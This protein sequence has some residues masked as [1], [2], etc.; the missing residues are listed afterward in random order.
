MGLFANETCWELRKTVVVVVVV[1][2]RVRAWRLR[3]LEKLASSGLRGGVGVVGARLKAWARNSTR[4]S[5]GHP[6]A[7]AVHAQQGRRCH[8]RGSLR[9]DLGITRGKNGGVEQGLGMRRRA[10]GAARP[11]WS[12]PATGWTTGDKVIEGQISEEERER[13]GLR[14]DRNRGGE[15]GGGGGMKKKIKVRG[16]LVDCSYII[17]SVAWEE[18]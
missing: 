16:F 2:V 14:G 15:R 4:N 18:Q 7:V 9:E 6:R 5:R 12:R 11:C 10:R 3:D 13:H 1:V 17:Y 8:R